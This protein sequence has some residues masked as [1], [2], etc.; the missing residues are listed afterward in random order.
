MVDGRGLD[1]TSELDVV[2]LVRLIENKFGQVTFGRGVLS[3]DFLIHF[4]ET[5]DNESKD[6]SFF[7]VLRVLLSHFEVVL[8]FELV[9]DLFHV[10]GQEEREQWSEFILSDFQGLDE[11]FGQKDDS[12]ATKQEGI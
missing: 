8:Q 4:L 10:L 9:N 5:N 3:L 6:F 12:L 2:R 11:N 7:L 1:L